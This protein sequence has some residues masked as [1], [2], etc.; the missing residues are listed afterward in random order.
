MARP[1][2]DLGADGR[3]PRMARKRASRAAPRDA[4]GKKKA[5]PT[6]KPP[7]VRLPRSGSLSADAVALTILDGL[8]VDQRLTDEDVI[9]VL[10]AWKFSPN[11]R[12]VNVCPEG[13]KSVQSDMLGIVR[14]RM[15]AKA[16]VAASTRAFPAVTR[17][18]CRYIREQQ[19]VELSGQTGSLKNFPFT[20]I[21]VNKGYKAKR[22]RDVNN[23]GPCACRALG[24]F[25]GGSLL[26][27]PRDAGPRVVKDVKDLDL[28]DAV[29]IDH[30]KKF[31]VFHGM[32]AHEVT[33]YS[34]GTR[35]SLVY[36]TATGYTWL[37]D[38]LK[39]D[40]YDKYGLELPP[41]ELLEELGTLADNAW[42]APAPTAKRPKRKSGTRAAAPK[43]ANVETPKS[44][45]AE[46]VA[47]STP[48]EHA[49]IRVR[50]WSALHSPPFTLGPLH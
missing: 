8:G 7:R 38:H 21:C 19:P 44:G 43:S 3:K 20:T 36:F 40:L 41:P 37:E 24:D 2:V 34:G 33:P 5:V 48:G 1:K 31:H 14:I 10:D 28:A 15:Y 50:P 30:T 26:H 49:A 17:L 18:L 42:G 39:V 9:S 23:I 12:R 45:N 4:D 46:G 11:Y 25:T 27:W 47:K 6:D 32:R 16:V 13:E 35:Y 22:H 29:T